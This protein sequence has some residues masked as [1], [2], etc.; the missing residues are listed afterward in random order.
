MS[1][2]REFERKGAVHRMS[3]A[4]KGEMAKWKEENGIKAILPRTQNQKREQRHYNR[5]VRC[6]ERCEMR[7]ISHG[8]A[9]EVRH[10]KPEKPHE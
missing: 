9:S 4:A 3:Q 5:T 6:L 2:T 7:K 10:I 8:P 1:V